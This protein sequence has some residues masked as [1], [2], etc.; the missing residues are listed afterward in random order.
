MDMGR[1]TAAQTTVETATGTTWRLRIRMDDSPGTLARITIRLAD[2]GCNILGLQVMPVPGGVLDELVVRPAPGLG[3]AELVEAIAAEGC[4]CA[5]VTDADVRELVEPATAALAAA[6]RA[7]DDPAK[8]ADV[9][10]DVLAADMVTLVPSNEA[11]PARTEGGHR[12][13]FPVGPEGALVARRSWA[14]FVQLEIARAQAMLGLL[15]AVRANLAGPSVVTCTD[16][17]MVVLRPGR[18]A[19]TDAVFALHTRCSTDTLFHRYHTGLRTVPRRWLHRLLMPPR[20]LS[21]L[22]IAGRE[23]V[24]LG[25]LIPSANGGP[26]EVSLLVADDWQRKGLGTALLGR[27]A[28]LGAA[29]GHRELVAVCLP[30]QDA[31][32]RAVLR[33]GLHAPEPDAKEGVLRIEIP[34]G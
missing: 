23:V 8:L 28:E 2:L 24:A 34:A 16:G 27:L 32:R 18:P 19:D 14:P 22:A 25:Q 13:V 4:E 9:L 7:V 11:N 5:G 31:V 20:G 30:G 6:G 10:R 3:R 15:A 33:A 21:L 29:A 12:R 17:A 26:A 1:T